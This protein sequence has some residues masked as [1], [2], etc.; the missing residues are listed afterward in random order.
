MVLAQF[1]VMFGL[2]AVNSGIL[3]TWAFGWV[4]P[5]SLDFPLQ[6]Q[7]ATC[8]AALEG[9]PDPARLL[10]RAQRLQLEMDANPPYQ[11]DRRQYRCAF[12]ILDGQGHLLFR[13]D[14]APLGVLS[15]ARSGVH[16]VQASNEGWRVVVREAAD[17]N[18]RVLVAESIRFRRNMIWRDIFTRSP[19][20]FL[21]MFL[22]FSLSTWWVSRAAL[23][24]LRR[25]AEDVEARHP[26]DLSPLQGHAGLSETRPVVE[27]LN[28]MF[29]RIGALL[30]GQRRF[31]ADAAHELRTPLAVVSAQAHVLAHTQEPELRLEAARELQQGVE[32]GAQVITQLLSFAALEAAVETP[33]R[34]RLDLAQLAREHLARLVPKAL[35]KGQDLGYEG[36]ESWPWE[37]D[38]AL[39]GSAVD[40]LLLNAIQYTPAAG[41]I[42]LRILQGPIETILEVEDTGP[43]IPENFREQVFERFTRLPGTQVPGSGLGLAIVRQVAEWHGGQASLASGPERRG[44]VAT[45]RLP[46]KPLAL[47][48]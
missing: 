10:A 32:R 37:G 45:I 11:E 19:M 23:K 26:G 16:D 8:L 35:A 40:N 33:S 30:A 48:C 6:G 46:G 4:Q 13:T 28:R 31:V 12:Q 38:A 43:G 2:W 9:E 27:A 20:N 21:F 36:P 47:G 17:G 29:A 14:A 34:C 42:T 24:P 22:V 18:L 41:A 25:L 39:L 3:V 44:L 7:A 1:L 15:R 5:R